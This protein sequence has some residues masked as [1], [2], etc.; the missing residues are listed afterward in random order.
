MYSGDLVIWCCSLKLNSD[1][2]EFRTSFHS[3][4]KQS[5][6]EIFW[7][8]LTAIQLWKYLSTFYSVVTEPCQKMH[9][10]AHWQQFC[11]LTSTP[12]HQYQYCST[13]PSGKPNL[14]CWCRF[15]CGSFSTHERQRFTLIISN[16]NVRAKTIEKVY[17]CGTIWIIMTGTPLHMVI[18]IIR[19]DK[20]TDKLVA[21]TEEDR[22]DLLHTILKRRNHPHIT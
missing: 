20:Y 22:S 6:L 14:F 18:I 16:L 9:L 15:D 4:K 3:G 8:I 12:H 19:V 13:C 1:F 7:D 21:S 17:K 11:Q 5:K 2:L 10:S